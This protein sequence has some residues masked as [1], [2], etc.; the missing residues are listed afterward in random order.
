MLSALDE[1]SAKCRH[2]SRQPA[3]PGHLKLIAD[4]HPV[5]DSVS[6]VDSEV[7]EYE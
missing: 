4:V 7:C 5:A 2:S 6:Y 3:H 1:G